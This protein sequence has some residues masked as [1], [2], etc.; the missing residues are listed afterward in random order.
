MRNGRVA[1][2]P[3]SGEYGKE[4]LR[5]RAQ[6]SKFKERKSKGDA[7]ALSFATDIKP[8]FREGDVKCMK[9]AGVH[10]DDAAWMSVPANAAKVYGAVSTGKM[11]P[12]AKWPADK[13]ARFK[14]WMDAGY[15]A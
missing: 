2:A 12:D 1:L 10:L 14:Q 13:V 6:E 4:P 11:P 5:V 7:M 8:L 9:P 3:K 15:P